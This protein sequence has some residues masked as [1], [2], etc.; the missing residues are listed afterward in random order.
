M[1]KK[2]V[3]IIP[4]SGRPELLSRTLE[5]LDKC[6]KPDNFCE[7]IVVEN[8]I[9]AGTDAVVRSFH[10]SSLNVRYLYS[11][12]ANKSAAL[13]L[14]IDPIME[15]LI[16]FTDDDVRFH[17]EILIKYSVSADGI[18]KGI[19]FGGPIEPDYEQEP[20]EW[21]K[22]YLPNSVL[23]FR[24]DKKTS[25]VESPIFSGCNWAA[26]SNDIIRAGG[27]SPNFGP[28]SKTNSTGQETEMQRRLLENGVK[29]LFIPEALVW[30]FVPKE[31]CSVDWA[32]KR[33]YRYF[34]G[35]AQKSQPWKQP[36]KSFLWT[37]KPF[38]TFFYPS[39]L[40]SALSKNKEKKFRAKY[41]LY[42]GCG[43]IKG[44][45]IAWKNHLG[46]IIFNLKQ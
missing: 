14:A 29:G 38:F 35:Q 2:L 19:F 21:L 3:V 26:F 20:D 6:I 44:T 16:F 33:N 12:N 25:K 13:N 5:S 42:A 41:Q 36:I 24:I 28:G 37:I 15:S 7:T 9:K 34:T 1:A 31:R 32:L 39:I 40:F 30:H 27:F 45:W 23:G 10:S 17:P 43:K 8:G 46:K 11:S 18:D 4:T 22:K